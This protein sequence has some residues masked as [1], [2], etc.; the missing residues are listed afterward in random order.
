MAITKNVCIIF[1]NR[2]DSCN[3]ISICSLYGGT[4]FYKNTKLIFAQNLRTI[5]PQQKNK[6]SN[7]QLSIVNKTAASAAQLAKC[8]L[9]YAYSRTTASSQQW[10]S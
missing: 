5:Q 1:C 10:R 2:E 6:V 4:L 9:I 8:I 7:F 3:Q